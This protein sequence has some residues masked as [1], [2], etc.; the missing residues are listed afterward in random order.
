MN[1]RDEIIEYFKNSESTTESN[2]IFFDSL[3]DALIGIS[4]TDEKVVYS[5]ELAVQILIDEGMEYEDAVEYID[6]N[7]IGAYLGE[8][9]PIFIRTF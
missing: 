8:N 6:F 1:K 3:D 2:L 4:I 7:L 9:T 5:Y